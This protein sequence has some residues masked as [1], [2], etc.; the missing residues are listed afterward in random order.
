MNK[1]ED[2]ITPQKLSKYFDI[3]SRAIKKVKIGK[4]REIDWEKKS[5]DFFDM[6]QRYFQDA[7]YFHEKNDFIN[8]FAALNYAHGWLDAGAR[9]GFFDVNFD[10]VLFTVDKEMFDDEEDKKKDI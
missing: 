10:N 7:K 9:L 6:A 5:H 3:T 4:Q 2:K 8:A 1:I